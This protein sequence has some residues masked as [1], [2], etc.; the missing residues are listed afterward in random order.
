LRRVS[1]FEIQS[2]LKN[3]YINQA[4]DLSCISFATDWAVP[5]QVLAPQYQKSSSFFYNGGAKPAAA[6]EKR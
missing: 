4:V 6:K 3:N 5:P 1:R 2:T